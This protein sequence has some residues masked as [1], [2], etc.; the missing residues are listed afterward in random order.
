MAGAYLAFHGILA[1]RARR[2]DFYENGI[3]FPGD[4]SASKPRFIAWSAIERFHWDGDSL[5]VARRLPDCLTRL[6]QAVG[7]ADFFQGSKATK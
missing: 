5:T 2:L 7:R 4:S 1:L 3:Y 6:A